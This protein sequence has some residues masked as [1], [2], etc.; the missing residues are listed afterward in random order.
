MAHW[1]GRTMRLVWLTGLTACVLLPGC[2]PDS[3]SYYGTTQS[4]YDGYSQPGYVSPGYAQPE[5]GVFDSGPTYVAPYAYPVPVQP[6]FGYSPGRDY[7]DREFRNRAFREQ[8]F[9]NDQDRYNRERFERGR[10]DDFRRGPEFRPPA[11]PPP[12]PSPP[13]GQTPPLRGGI[14]PGAPRPMPQP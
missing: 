5:Y 13:P 4:G 3:G 11:P 14:F 1:K 8:Q 12:R 9:R 2:A 6:G 7:R 10:G